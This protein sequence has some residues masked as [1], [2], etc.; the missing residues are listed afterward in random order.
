[1][2]LKEDVL[3]EVLKIKR[4]SMMKISFILSRKTMIKMKR[5]EMPN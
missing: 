3:T 4:I 1:M 5:R 2:M